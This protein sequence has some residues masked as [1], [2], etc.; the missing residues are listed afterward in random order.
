MAVVQRCQ[1]K[2]LRAIVDAPCHVTNNMIHEDLGVPAVQ[3]VM[4]EG[5]IKHRTNLEF[6]P[7]TSTPSKR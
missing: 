2:I 3:E 7:I 6:Q 5:S 4:H 1:S